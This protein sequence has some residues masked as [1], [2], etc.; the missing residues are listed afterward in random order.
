MATAAELIRR[1]APQRAAALVGLSR[2]YAEGG[3]Y[4][5]A[6][7]SQMAA[8]LTCIAEAIARRNDRD[9][10]WDSIQSSISINAKAA[11]TQSVRASAE[12]FRN[13]V[14]DLLPKEVAPTLVGLLGHL[15]KDET[16]KPGLS[17]AIT[18]ARL[19]GN[20]PVEHIADCIRIRDEKA[21]AAR[22]A[23][24]SGKDWQS[25]EAQYES[26]LAAFDAWVTQRSIQIGDQDLLWAQLRWALATEALENIG[27]L[28]E[29]STY[30]KEL[31]RSRLTWV[32]GPS[33]MHLLAALFVN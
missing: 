32:V 29:N 16:A 2:A 14:S 17:M 11:A 10:I 6:L 28:P 15:P 13:A 18:E 3:D 8:D 33:E 4:L 9:E 31:V 7:H 27:G 21:A 24:Q 12:A 22:E 19:G 5:M 25:V 30:A 23:Q 1:D 26:D 20:S